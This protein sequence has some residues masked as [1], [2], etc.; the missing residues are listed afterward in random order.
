MHSS[1]WLKTLS[2]V[3]PNS[4]P[5]R[6]MILKS[7]LVMTSLDPNTNIT[8]CF[9]P[10]IKNV[11]PTVSLYCLAQV[12]VIAGSGM[13][14]LWCV[15]VQDCFFL[16]L[17]CQICGQRWKRAEDKLKTEETE[18]KTNECIF[19]NKLRTPVALGST[20]FSCFPPRR[21][22]LAVF[23][24]LLRES[25]HACLSFKRKLRDWQANN[26]VFKTKLRGI[27]FSSFPISDW[28]AAG[29]LPKPSVSP[30]AT[31]AAREPRFSS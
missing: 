16:F 21:L 31:P 13:P 9:L 22:S 7:Q 29:S 27:N 23:R 14:S 24:F 12:W 8:L 6:T 15:R 20:N 3:S 19:D 10:L 26:W 25:L 11:R 4:P 28:W 30:R 5:L 17:L 2:L 1:L 18:M